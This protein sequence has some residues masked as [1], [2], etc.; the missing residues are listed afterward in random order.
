MPFYLNRRAVLR[1]IGASLALPALE[2]MTNSK[3][4]FFRVAHAASQPA[5]VRYLSVMINNG[6]PQDMWRPTDN[7]DGTY[8]LNS[9]L[10]SIS[11]HKADFNQITGLNGQFLSSVFA[12]TDGAHG[13]FTGHTMHSPPFD[14]QDQAGSAPSIE[15]LL[16]QKLGGSTKFRSLTTSLPRPQSDRYGDSGRSSWIG[17]KQPSPFL[18]TPAQLASRVLGAVAPRDTTEDKRRGSLLD[19][20][21]SDTNRLLKRLSAQDQARLD[22]HLTAVRDMEIQLKVVANTCVAPTGSFPER[23]GNMSND[24]IKAYDEAAAPLMAKLV[25]FAFQCDLTRYAH[26][27]IANAPPKD[28]NFIPEDDVDHAPMMND[29][30]WSHRPGWPGNLNLYY[31]DKKMKYWANFLDAMKA[32]PEGDK[33]LLYNSI[34]LLGCDIADGAAHSFTNYPIV[35]VGQAGG[36]IKTGRHLAYNGESFNRLHAT[37]LTAAGLPTP[38][39]GSDKSTPLPG[40]TA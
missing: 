37:L 38:V 27:E 28:A 3:G 16:G 36:R 34:S 15:C 19:K 20:Y 29:H 18:Q 10:Q 39:F 32:S 24:Q 1:G 12:H 5:P 9:G 6:P 40:L 35:Q 4:L 22:Q 17:D 2:C 13:F 31:I 8:T 26:F 33:T 21:M 11:Q 25:V 7:P 23:A 30:Y 14:G